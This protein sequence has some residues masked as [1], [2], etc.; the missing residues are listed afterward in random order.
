MYR[1]EE[2]WP[3]V[4]AGLLRNLDSIATVIFVNDEPWGKWR[5]DW[6]DTPHTLLDRPHEGWGGH[7]CYNQGMKASST[8][9]VLTI[10][11]DVM[12]CDDAIEEHLD[13]AAPHALIV[14]V[15]HDAYVTKD[16]IDMVWEDQRIT[17]LTGA[18][19]TI[20]PYIVGAAHV[21]FHRESFH[22]LGG[23]DES[24]KG[25]TPFDTHLALRWATRYGPSSIK[26]SNGVAYHVNPSRYRMHQADVDKMEDAL[27]SYASSLNMTERDALDEVKKWK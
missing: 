16:G 21:M 12:L 27:E 3:H 6:T 14:G 18:P 2:Y 26:L 1:Q 15:L 24:F 22:A 8:E 11:G 7:R 19:P 25:H 5:P 23:Y 4:K 20:N 9:Y 17:R 13:I 10:D